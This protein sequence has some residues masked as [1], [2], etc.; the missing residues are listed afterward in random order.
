M[1]KFI[2][3]IFYFLFFKEE[4]GQLE[5]RAMTVYSRQSPINTNFT[6]FNLEYGMMQ[7]KIGDVYKILER[8]AKPDKRLYRIKT[9]A[10]EI[11]LAI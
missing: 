10:S 1:F 4:L 11:Q 2:L 5:Y 9:N 8:T 7:D 3:N 6:H